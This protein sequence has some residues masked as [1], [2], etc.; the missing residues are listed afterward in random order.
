MN[1]AELRSP[2][3]GKLISYAD[4]YEFFSAL[5]TTGRLP[6]W[7]SKRMSPLLTSSD[8]AVKKLADR[9]RRT[10][11]LFPSNMAA[12]KEYYD[13]TITKFKDFS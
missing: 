9:I 2:Q 1:A 13:T 11:K 6:D 12:N 5:K 4:L 8:P 10:V 7:F 3:S